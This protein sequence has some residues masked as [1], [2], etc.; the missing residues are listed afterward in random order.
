[1]I[2]RLYTIKYLSK[3]FLWREVSVCSSL[4]SL[5]VSIHKTDV[6]KAVPVSLNT[7][8]KLVICIAD[9]HIS[10]MG[11]KTLILNTNLCFN[12]LLVAL[13]LAFQPSIRDYFGLIGLLILS[14]K[15]NPMGD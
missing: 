12:T 15:Q 7:N 1:M 9:S 5:N 11:P 2:H 4:Y 8:M 6:F 13:E 3:G 14:T 10:I